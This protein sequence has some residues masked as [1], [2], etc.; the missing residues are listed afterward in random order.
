MISIS[1]LTLSVISYVEPSLDIEKNIDQETDSTGGI[2]IYDSTTNEAVTSNVLSV[3]ENGGLQITGLDPR[4]N[5][6]LTSSL[7][8]SIKSQK[9]TN[10]IAPNNVIYHY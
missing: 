6:V 10:M 8:K 1:E 7:N 3:T 2:L 5:F 9:Y 4:I